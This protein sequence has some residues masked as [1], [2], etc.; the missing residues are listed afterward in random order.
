MDFRN[1]CN[2][3]CVKV[4]TLSLLLMYG[5][6]KADKYFNEEIKQMP[7]HQNYT[8]MYSKF[9]NNR[10]IT[11]IEAELLENMT[12]YRD[13]Q[14]EEE[15]KLPQKAAAKASMGLGLVGLA[16]AC[17]KKFRKKVSE[18][19]DKKRKLGRLP[20][21]SGVGVVTGLGTGFKF[22]VENYQEAIH[23]NPIRGYGYFPSM[24]DII[25]VAG[26][27]L[28]AYWNIYG[29]SAISLAGGIIIGS[30]AGAVGSVIVGRAGHH[31]LNFFREPENKIKKEKHIH[32][33]VID[34]F[35]YIG[36]SIKRGYK[37]LTEFA[38]YS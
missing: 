23:S 34:E 33:E 36:E 18:L 14:L 32:Q 27:N 19:T 12:K 24:N 25:E 1:V 4:G 13:Y 9:T 31:V 29:N 11:P 21:A 22:M 17:S 35:K 8:E 10:E 28:V 20:I 15:S 16:Y 3:R 7:A 26:D 37:S 30:M 5:G 2:N 6:F 38:K